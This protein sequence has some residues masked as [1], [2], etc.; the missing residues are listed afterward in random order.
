MKKTFVIVALLMIIARVAHTQQLPSGFWMGQTK[1]ALPHLQYGLGSDR[2]G[3]AKMT[4]LDTNVVL[5]V[6]DSTADMYKI[7]LSQY[8]VGYA[9]KTTIIRNDSIH[10]KPYYLSESW[11]VYGDSLY[12][13][14]TINLN[15][16]LPY[17]SIQQINPSRLVVDIFGATSNSNWITQLKTVKEITN[18]YY[19]QLDDDVLRVFIELKHKQ[20]WGHHISY[21]TTGT[22]LIIRIKRQPILNISKLKIAIDPGHGGTNGGTDGN[23]SGRSEKSLTLQYAN[24]LKEVLKAAGV[25]SVFLTRTKDTTL[26][27]A[28]RSAM[29][30]KYDP[31]LLIS[32]HFNSSGSDT[33]SGTSTYYRYIGYRPLS[34]AILNQLLQLDL[35]NYGNVGGFNFGLNGPT[36]YPN[37][38]VEV[39]FLSNRREEQ[40]ILDPNFRKRVATRITRGIKD[41]LMEMQ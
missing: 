25:K 30:L 19:E 27:M 17:R 24:E 2:L 38:L 9:P 4:Y 36:E 41:W 5:R 3:G 34:T 23:I 32:I 22:R 20:H 35:K 21:D 26:S 11:R 6:I 15:E 37:T 7:Q 13:Y 39:G 28:E 31:N 40:R 33:V 14:V 16:K 29:L 1:G 8:R 12:D 10:P 18:A